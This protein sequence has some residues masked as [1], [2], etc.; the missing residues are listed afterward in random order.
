MLLLYLLASSRDLDR[1]VLCSL[2]LLCGA[3]SLIYTI[4]KE[5]AY[6]RLLEEEADC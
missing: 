5:R 1:L 4:V 3:P 2:I 6:K